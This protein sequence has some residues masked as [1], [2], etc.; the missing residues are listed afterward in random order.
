[1]GL[2][3]TLPCQCTNP[4]C[5][6]TFQARNPVGGGGSN[7]RFTGNMT[8]CPRCGKKAYYTDWN[9]DSQGIFHLRGFFS[10]LRDFQDAEKLRTLKIDLES[11][12]DSITAN[13]LA[14][15]LVRLEPGFEKL[16]KT[17]DSIPAKK[18]ESLANTILAIITI[19][20]MI[21]TWQ[22]SN[23]NHEESMALQREQ[24][25]LS[26]EQ[27]EYQKERDTKQN[28]IDSQADQERDELKRQI[29]HLQ[30]QLEEKLN[31]ISSQELNGSAGASR[32]QG[33]KLKGSYRNKPCP[34]ESGKKAKKCHPNGYDI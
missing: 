20:L 17:L 11:A 13:E 29:D 25:H 24:Q 32:T 12:N 1:M 23:E 16:K 15:A 6:I 30:R 9:T 3:D 31:E 33:S 10:A 18:I 19:I 27:F 4:K 22:A 21:K 34:C 8:N 14:D 26:R 28:T 7:I 2:P 5:G